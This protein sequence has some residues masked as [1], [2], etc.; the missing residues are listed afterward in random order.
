MSKRKGDRESGGIDR[1]DEQVACLLVFDLQAV[2]D[3]EGSG[4]RY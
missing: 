2:V 3:A 4:D 1:T